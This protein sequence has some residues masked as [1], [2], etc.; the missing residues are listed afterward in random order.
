MAAMHIVL[1]SA[2]G[3]RELEFEPRHH[4]ATIEDLLR[5]ALGER[6]PQAIVVGDRVV[7][8]SCPITDSGLHE[9]AVVTALQDPASPPPAHAASTS[10]YELVL[11]AGRDVGRTIAL[12][13]GRSTIGRTHATTIELPDRTVSREHCELHLAPDGSAT[14]TDLGSENL[15]YVE[16]R[17]IEA[18]RPASI[19]PGFVIEVGAFALTVRANTD[20]DRPQSL[21]LRRQVGPG[22]TVPH[23]RP[24]RPMGAAAPAEIEPPRAPSDPPKAHFSIASTLGPL[25]MAVVMIGVTGNPQY[26]LFM[27][28]TPLIAVGT[29]VESRRR[30]TK[31][32]AQSRK[33]YEAE[34]REL[35]RRIDE[36]GEAERARLR[37]FCPDPAEVLRRA[38]LPSTRLWERRSHHEDFLLLYAGLTDLPWKPP[39]KDGA[40]KLPP[41]LAQRV[42]EH[43]LPVAPISVDISHGGIVGIVGDREAALATARSLVCQVAV[44]HGPA[45]V[46]IGVFVDPGREPDWEWCKWLPHT[47]NAGGGGDRWL[48]HERKAS[49]DMLRALGGRR[50]HGHD[51]RR[52][53]LRR[54]DRGQERARPR[55]AERRRR[56]AHAV[57]GLPGARGDRGRGHR[58]R[59][60]ARPPAGRLQ[61]RHRDRRGDRRRDDP[62]P[63]GARRGPRR[64]ARGTVGRRPPAA[65]RAISPAS[66]TRSS[67]SPAPA[68][69]TACG[70][71]RCSSSTAS[72]PTRCASAGAPPAATPARSPR[73]ASPRAARFAST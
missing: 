64:P 72:T 19:E 61:H 37:D 31:G 27:L 70:C 58:R 50:R 33:E 15:T 7:P 69:P 57:L 51:A 54:P 17:P 28:L 8:G 46:T 6:H 60:D 30:S 43:K 3:E 44:H 40:H 16:G 42:A 1:R 48:S 55:P 11:L 9:G 62:P 2:A 36:A 32:G 67:S 35:E 53:R 10:G 13:V 59:G 66:T 39:V 12:A 22:G 34:L 5:A 25:V 45:D 47:R 29:Y 41:E 18:G 23:N 24:P 14:I 73:S 21:D 63:R 56:G 65:A 71:C 68:C 20:D 4:E 49:D 52:A 26:A 38:T